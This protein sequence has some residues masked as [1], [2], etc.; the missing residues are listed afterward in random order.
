[1]LFQFLESV[2]GSADDGVK[3]GLKLLKLMRFDAGS[4]AL[5]VSKETLKHFIDH[6]INNKIQGS[7]L[8]YLSNFCPLESGC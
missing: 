1:M 5:N 2:L 7:Q 3:I 6:N 4:L 8:R